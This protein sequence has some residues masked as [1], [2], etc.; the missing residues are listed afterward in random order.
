ME[1]LT[2]EISAAF[3][4]ASLGVDCA[5]EHHASYLDHW[6][7]LLKSD[8]RAI[9][10]AASKAQAA[11]DFILSRIRPEQTEAPAEEQAGAAA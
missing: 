4:C 8:P 1:E 9:I 11:S 10:T 2:A 7:Q 3:L 6:R 5:L